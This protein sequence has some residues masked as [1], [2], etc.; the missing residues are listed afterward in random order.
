VEALTLPSNRDHAPMSTPP[1]R[2]LPSPPRHL[3]RSRWPWRLMLV[4]FGLG[5][6]SAYYTD[7]CGM[8]VR[9]GG[10]LRRTE[11]AQFVQSWLGL[12]WM[13]DRL[14]RMS[15][16]IPM[17]V[18]PP[19]TP[20]AEQLAAW[21]AL[22]E[23]VRQG[24]RSPGPGLASGPACWDCRHLSGPGHPAGPPATPRRTA[25]AGRLGRWHHRGPPGGSTEAS[26]IFRRRRLGHAGW[27]LTFGTA[28][29]LLSYWVLQAEQIMVLLDLTWAG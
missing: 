26:M 27:T 24:D 28:G 11:P 25:P 21:Q 16:A 14:F 23:R 18:E 9:G 10:D 12:D 7:R 20:S 3:T 2:H 22:V 8:P 15:E 4:A 5:R 19:P 17:P 29:G 13:V 1:P 6:R